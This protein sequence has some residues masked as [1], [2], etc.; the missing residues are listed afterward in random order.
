MNLSDK[1]LTELR[2]IATRMNIKWHHRAKAETL[3][4]A[5]TKARPVNPQPMHH[6]AETPVQPTITNTEDD[7]RQVMQP[8]L[9]KEGFLLNFPGD[10]TWIIQY[11]GAEESGNCSIPLRVIRNKAENVSR[12]RRVLKTMGKDHMNGTYADTILA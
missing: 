8:F 3:I 10:G 12:G 11:K 2:N 4:N 6:K 7:I 1:S 9:A 5:I